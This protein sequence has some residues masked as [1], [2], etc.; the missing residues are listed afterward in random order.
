[1]QTQVE[2]F[3]LGKIESDEW[4][5][6]SK[7]P[8]ERDLSL[9]LEVSRTTVRNA[10]QALTTRGMFDRRIGQGT[11][12]RQ[13]LGPLEGASRRVA[14]GNIGY[15][16]CKERSLRKPIS[17]EAFY[18]DVFAGVE[19]ETVRSGRHM[20]FAYLDDRNADEVGAFRG[21]LD[22][23]DGVVI[24]E[25]C[26]ETFLDSVADSG[27]PAALIGPTAMHGRI[28]CISMDIGAGVRRALQYLR[29][30]GHRRIGIVNGPLD[31][32]SA[33]V[34]FEAW[35]DEM[36]SG[37]Q[38]PED[39]LACGGGGWSAEAG[40]A[41][42]NELLARRPD[43]TA[44]FCANDLLAIGALSAISKRGLKVPEDVSV[45]GFDDTELSRHAVPPLTTMR[46]YSRDM[47]R[48]AVR[49][50][51]ERLEGGSIPPVKLEYPIDL[52]PRESCRE[53]RRRA[54]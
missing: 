52:V 31:L 27:V 41:A 37:G 39:S 47:A 8:S 6:G 33:R 43:V 1:M 29:S 30:L 3:I 13:K 20:L 15:V 18:F 44:L 49:R 38:G 2:N 25:A 16:I 24:E 48:S 42:A 28:D 40:A 19:E 53:V 50:I 17:A 34:R 5:V 23:V 35:R 7:I 51:L 26:D 54:G 45:I 9:K 22:K 46:I 32:E 10:V 12:V 11:F 4:P 21:F 36:R 14:K